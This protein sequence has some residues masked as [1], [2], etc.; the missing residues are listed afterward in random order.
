M[1][2]QLEEQLRAR[3]AECMP[4][5]PSGEASR[6]RL[7]LGVDGSVSVCR[8]S[9]GA[10]AGHPTIS[11]ATRVVERAPQYLVKLGRQPVSSSDIRL[12]HKS[13]ARG[14]YEH[15]RATAGLSQ[16]GAPSPPSCDVLLYNEA[17]EITEASI[18]NVALQGADGRWRTPPLDCGLLAGTMR[19]ALL[20]AGELD[21]GVLTLDDLREATRTGQQL[22]G[23]NAVRGVYRL[24]VLDEHESPAHLQSRL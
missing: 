17:A 1:H 7:S 4:S 16:A 10:E 9:L 15:A 5:W 8:A 24:R 13:S 11:L 2:A 23:F 20:D 19:A 6:V 14:V 3:L 21:E 18:A 22:V 12:H